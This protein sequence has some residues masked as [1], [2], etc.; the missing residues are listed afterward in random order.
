MENSVIAMY[1]YSIGEGM[2]CFGFGSIFLPSS[3]S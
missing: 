1:V 2:G 3:I